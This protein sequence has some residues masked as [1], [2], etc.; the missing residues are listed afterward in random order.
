MP[1]RIR[2]ATVDDAAAIA[3]L[4]N[5]VIAEGRLTA[6]DQPFSVEDER[7]FIRQLGPRSVLHL[8]TDN[9]A[10]LG[11]QSIDRLSLWASS[12][13]HVATLGTWLKPEARGRGLGPMLFGHS[14]AFARAH[15]Y[16]KIVIQVL[17]VNSRAL[18]FYRG[19]GFRD[20]GVA[21]D[22]VRLGG[23]LYDEIYLEMLLD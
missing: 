19:L 3:G 11:L 1:V 16:S 23:T 2:R 21:K 22:H 12:M 18:S 6:F 5:A 14:V 9:G 17:A 10:I 7:Q 15:G 8:A 4:L 20:I 13:D